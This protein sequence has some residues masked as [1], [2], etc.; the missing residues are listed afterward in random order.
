MAP[1]PANCC[2]P[3]RLHT[4]D[5][6]SASTQSTRGKVE[7]DTTRW[8][9]AAPVTC[10][11]LMLVSFEDLC[12]L[13]WMYTSKDV[14]YWL[15]EPP[16][17]CF[18]AFSIP[19]DDIKHCIVIFGAGNGWGIKNASECLKAERQLLCDAYMKYISQGDISSVSSTKSYL[20]C[21]LKGRAPQIH[22]H[23]QKWIQAIDVT[24]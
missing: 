17:H 6:C 22:W 23:R 16:H 14:N 12:R 5:H 8:L 7:A 15:N 21:S 1:L 18:M 2:A 20:W 24:K 3:L 9:N 13:K 10:P 11:D 4:N 19:S